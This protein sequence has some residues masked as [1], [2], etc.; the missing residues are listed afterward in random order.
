[1]TIL[2]CLLNPTID[3]IY[4]IENFHVGGT[5]KVI[6]SLIYPVGKAISFSLGIRELCKNNDNIKVF[7]LIGEE[8]ISLYSKF[9]TQKNIDYE[10][11]KI[12]GQ[13]RSNKTINDPIRNTTTH[14]RERGFELSKID[15]QKLI[16][17][18]QANIN[19]GDIILF[20]GSIHP[21]VENN[22]Y[23]RLIEISKKKGAF[24]IL[25]TNGE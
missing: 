16:D 1:M 14:I 21:K 23:Y 8:D 4:T 7:G 25:D 9:L 24:T 18:L 12:K 3:Q 17:L 5:F 6:D 2:S 11:I 22:I 19:E 10:F 20:S 13:T 15:I